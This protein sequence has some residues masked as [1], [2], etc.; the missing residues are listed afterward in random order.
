MAHQMHVQNLRLAEQNFH[1]EKQ[2]DLSAVELGFMSKDSFLEK[3]P[4]N[5]D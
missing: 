1:M 3:Y 5:K 2:N 4:S